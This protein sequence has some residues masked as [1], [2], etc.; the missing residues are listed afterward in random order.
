MG[1][2]VHVHQNEV[3][4]YLGDLAC[5]AQSTSK[6]CRKPLITPQFNQQ[7][8]GGGGG[9]DRGS[10]EKIQPTQSDMDAYI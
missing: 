8:W 6:V 4:D 7:G 1:S 10:P 5:L 2:L 3:V 9:K